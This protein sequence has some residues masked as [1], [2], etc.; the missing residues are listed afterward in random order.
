MKIIYEDNYFIAI[1][2]EAGIEVDDNLINIIKK[3]YS[4]I[5]NLYLVHRIDKFTSGIV[6]LARDE[7]TKKYFEDAFKNKTINKVYHAIVNGKVKK[8]NGTIDI[9]IGIDK[10]NPNRRIPLSIKEG[11]ES[12]IT[13]YKVLKRLNEHTLL[14]LK[15]LTGRTHQIRVH[16]SYIGH[17]IIGDKIYSKNADIY[18]MKGFALIAKEIHFVHPFTKKDIDINI[19]YNKEFLIR[20]KL[21]ESS[22]RI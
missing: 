15:P 22:K 12:A 11:G 17:P 3:E 20:L 13:H 1:D 9:S 7:E 16:L 21:L 4:H 14:E 19:K 5:D 10:K 6:I 8:E 2:K 18:K